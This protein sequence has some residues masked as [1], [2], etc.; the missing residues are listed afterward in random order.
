MAD[1][2]R[3]AELDLRP[4]PARLLVPAQM[5][6]HLE[7]F[8]RPPPPDIKASTSRGN[9][10]LLCLQARS[11]QFL[12]PSKRIRPPKPVPRRN[13]TFGGR[14]YHEST[15]KKKRLV[16]SCAKRHIEAD[17]CGSLFLGHLGAFPGAPQKIFCPP[18]PLPAV[19]GGHCGYFQESF[20]EN[21]EPRDTFSKRSMT[22]ACRANHV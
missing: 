10:C 12:G 5:S 15:H 21:A 20:K 22:F 13:I 17:L 9:T 8:P 16:K 19:F 6:R 1:G 18:K 14:A 11:G 4:G 3:L 7:G 2:M